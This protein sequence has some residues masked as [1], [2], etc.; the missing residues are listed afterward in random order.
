MN[1]RKSF[2]TLFKPFVKTVEI[3]NSLHQAETELAKPP[4]G[5]GGPWPHESPGNSKGPDKKT[6]RKD[7]GCAPQ[8]HPPQSGQKE[9]IAVTGI[10]P[11]QAHPITPE[12]ER[13]QPPGPAAQGQ[14][15][16]RL[17]PQLTITGTAEPTLPEPFAPGIR[18]KGQLVE[19]GITQN[20]VMSTLLTEGANAALPDVLEHVRTETRDNEP[21]PTLTQAEIN[22]IE[23]RS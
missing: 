21:A 14:D 12:N 22:S 7:S 13:E 9:R 8:Q 6:G 16:P 17:D 3:P 18:R 11:P 4:G 2:R 5:N 19:K 20:A 1:H 15:G 23:K 10:E